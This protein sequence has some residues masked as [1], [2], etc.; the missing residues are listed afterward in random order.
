[1]TLFLHKGYSGKIG[2]FKG[3]VPIWE[4]CIYGTNKLIKPSDKT[5][6]ALYHQRQTAGC[7]FSVVIL[8]RHFLC[9]F[10]L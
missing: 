3:A 5:T 10:M 8:L 1:M 7:V 9:K 2:I 6:T 4:G